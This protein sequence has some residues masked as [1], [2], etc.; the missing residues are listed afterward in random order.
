VSRVVFYLFDTIQT[1][2]NRFTW[3]LCLLISSFESIHLLLNHI[4]LDSMQTILTRIMNSLW[5]WSLAQWYDSHDLWIVSIFVLGN[6]NRFKTGLN[7][8]NS[9]F[10]FLVFL[11]SV[12][13]NTLFLAKILHLPPFSIYTHIL[14]TPKPLNHLHL[15]SLDSPNLIV[16]LFLRLNTFS[17]NLCGL[18]SHK[19][20]EFYRDCKR[21][22]IPLLILINFTFTHTHRHKT[23]THTQI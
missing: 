16:H 14:I 21:G 19:L 13:F 8:I 12:W 23:H 9:C 22:L 20:L 3:S 5:L 2:L 4:T 10:F 15:F 6:L 18:L 17:K 11:L 1:T 7:R